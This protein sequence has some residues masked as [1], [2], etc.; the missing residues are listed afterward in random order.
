MKKANAP[1]T[2][3]EKARLA[4]IREKAS[5]MKE[6]SR[7]KYSVP[8]PFTAIDGAR[9]IEHHDPE[10]EENSSAADSVEH[11]TISTLSRQ[12]LTVTPPRL[13]CVL[14]AGILTGNR[15]STQRFGTAE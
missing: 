11:K 8:V 2:I 13:L 5:Q 12:S 15:N 4:F 3:K 7:H 10:P 9:V 14:K 6:K 1:P